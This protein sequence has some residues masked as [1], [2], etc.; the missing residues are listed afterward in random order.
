MSFKI[1]LPD[2]V[3]TEL[4]LS[5]SPLIFLELRFIVQC[6][7]YF[8]VEQ[9]F[10]QD[11]LGD[12]QLQ[13]AIDALSHVIYRAFEEEEEDTNSQYR[14]SELLI[15]RRMCDKYLESIKGYMKEANGELSAAFSEVKKEYKAGRWD[16]KKLKFLEAVESIWVSFFITVALRSLDSLTVKEDRDENIFAVRI[17][18]KDDFWEYVFPITP[19]FN[20]EPS[21]PIRMI[22]NDNVITNAMVSKDHDFSTIPFLAMLCSTVL[23]ELSQR[24]QIGKSRDME[25]SPLVV[26][27]TTI[28]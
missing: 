15:F 17:D 14:D 23:M 11:L 18:K 24:G 4:S 20:S 6:F 22:V 28:Q 26:T 16:D 12:N 8:V 25:I 27:S 1:N 10:K 19:N 2:E 9:V 21:L 13:R 5:H 7:E 3:P